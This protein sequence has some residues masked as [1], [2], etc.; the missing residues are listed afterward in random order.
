[1][2]F[3]QESGSIRVALDRDDN[4]DDVG[5]L[6]LRKQESLRFRPSGRLG[7]RMS[8]KKVESGR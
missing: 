8:A 3:T 4:T 7:E 5:T 1:M 2:G 6:I